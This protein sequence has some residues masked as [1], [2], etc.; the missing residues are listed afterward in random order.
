MKKY[1]IV[2]CVDLNDQY[3]CDAD[4]TPLVL[5][6]NYVKWLK[7]YAKRFEWYEIYQEN[8][9]GELHLIDTFRLD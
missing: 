4:R 1:L 7:I 8:L 2:K 6:D 9:T 3:E 5:V